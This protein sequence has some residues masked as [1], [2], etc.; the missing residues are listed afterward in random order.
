MVDDLLAPASRALLREVGAGRDFET[1]LD[2]GCGPGPTSRLIGE[3]I[4]PARLVGLDVSETFL[5]LARAAVPQG[6]FLRHDVRQLPWPGSPADLA[7]ARYL[8]THL[9]DPVARLREWMTQLRPGGLL[10]VEENEWIAC[11]EPVFARYLE[12][13]GELLDARGQDLYVGRRLAAIEPRLQ[14]VSRVAEVSSPTAPVAT[15]FRLNLSAWAARVDP[16]RSAEVASLDR[17]LANLEG[18]T[19]PS[20][21]TWGLRQLVFGRE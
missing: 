12:I 20:G 1:V 2:L 10:V 18:S 11:S 4:R 16:S 13:A 9:P 15:M 17:E 5:R 14:R 6:E 3:V 21:I 19:E 8:L 7:Y